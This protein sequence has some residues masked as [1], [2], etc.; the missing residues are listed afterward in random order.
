ME[1][2]ENLRN[3]TPRRKP[4][5]KVL[6]SVLVAALAAFVLLP[7]TNT[8]SSREVQ[9]AESG[10]ITGTKTLDGAVT[11]Q[12]FTFDLYK[13]SENGAVESEKRRGRDQ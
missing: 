7:I 12:E 5:V 2:N 13:R 4:F 6:V 1:Q 10:Q 3:E 9:A 8:L 11:D